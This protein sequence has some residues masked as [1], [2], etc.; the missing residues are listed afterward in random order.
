MTAL[1][2]IK[3][4]AEA[5]SGDLDSSFGKNGKINANFG[6]DQGA[7]CVAM[8]QDGM[9]L[10]GAGAGSIN[11]GYLAVVR[12]QS[13]GEIDTTFGSNGLAAAKTPVA[14][15]LSPYTTPNGMILQPDGKIIVAG[16]VGYGVRADTDFALVRYNQDGSLDAFFGNSGFVITDIFG[17]NDISTAVALQPDGKIIQIG[18]AY[19]NNGMTASLAIIRYNQDGSL[20]PSFGK[21]GKSTIGSLGF[22][23]LA[24]A[25]VFQR[26]GKIVVGGVALKDEDSIIALA[27]FN[28]DGHLDKTFGVNGLTTTE[29]FGYYAF[30]GSIIAQD[31]HILVAG[32]I[33]RINSTESDYLLV[34]Y[35]RDGLLDRRFGRGGKVTTDFFNNFDVASV[36]AVQRDDKILLAGYT[37]VSDVDS[38]FAI[39]RYN[40]N[41]S[42]DWGFGKG[43]KVTTDFFGSEDTPSAIAVQRDGRIV[44]VGAASIE[45]TRDIAIVRY[46]H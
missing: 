42:L 34:R 40:E 15:D 46:H 20:D 16:T 6:S 8:Q 1:L 31:D 18:L 45:G 25:L 24:N 38:D 7:C 17:E 2:G 5:F 44:V 4:T 9:I 22:T 29:F 19:E 35:N 12:Y 26:N 43:G 13:N 14:D 11:G 32:S 41:G 37:R 23:N 27:R 10:V 36:I 3:V 39:V 28:S 21:G 30:A 33:S